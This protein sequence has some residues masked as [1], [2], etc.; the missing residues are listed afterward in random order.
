MLKKFGVPFN[1][2][3]IIKKDI[4]AKEPKDG[5]NENSAPAEITT[6]ETDYDYAKKIKKLLNVLIS[7]SKS[8]Y[9]EFKELMTDVLSVGKEDGTRSPLPDHKICMKFKEDMSQYTED[10]INNPG[11]PI[12]SPEVLR[13]LIKWIEELD[14]IVAKPKQNLLER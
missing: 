13:V 14:A 12:K 5:N 11:V 3:Q 8:H 10:E 2:I 4:K 7:E 6:R 9:Y 1:P